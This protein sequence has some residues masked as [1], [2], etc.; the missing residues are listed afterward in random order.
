MNRF[1]KLLHSTYKFRSYT[2]LRITLKS[3]EVNDILT[4]RKSSPFNDDDLKVIVASFNIPL[5]TLNELIMIRSNLM[6]NGTLLLRPKKFKIK[7]DKGCFRWTDCNEVNEVPNFD[8]TDIDIRYSLSNTGV[9]RFHPDEYENYY[10][11]KYHLKIS[12]Y[13][14]QLTDL[15]KINMDNIEMN[16]YEFE[17]IKL[18]TDL[19]KRIRTFEKRSDGYYLADT[20]IP[21][22]QINMKGIKYCGSIEKYKLEILPDDICLVFQRLF[23]AFDYPTLIFNVFALIFALIS[24]YIIMKK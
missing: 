8:I 2:D 6:V 20:K 15:F 1:G 3:N 7:Y 13:G 4:F 19:I 9:Y 21:F 5:E 14:N 22:K 18:T 24:I 11:S 16:V 23:A 12:D 10:Y 17:N